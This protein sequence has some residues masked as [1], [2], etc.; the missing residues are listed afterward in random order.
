M[1]KFLVTICA[2][3]FFAVVANAQDTKAKTCDKAKTSCCAK[4]ADGTACTKSADAKA[5]TKDAK[6]CTKDAKTAEVA[7][8]KK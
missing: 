2:V 7:K 4:K 6:A 5:C 8:D 3:A 1:K